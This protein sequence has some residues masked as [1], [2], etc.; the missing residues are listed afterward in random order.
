MT[1]FLKNTK[2]FLLSFGILTMAGGI[3][4]LIGSKVTVNKIEDERDN[5][6]S[7]YQTTEEFH[8]ARQ[9]RRLS[10]DN[11]FKMEALSENEYKEKL[12]YLDSDEFTYECLSKNKTEMAVKYKN[13][14][15]NLTTQIENKNQLTKASM[16]ITLAGGGIAAGGD[17]IKIDKYEYEEE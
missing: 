9:N 14:I 6:Y 16:L 12:K 3:G 1:G 13:N 17:Y 2:I 8:I 11:A 5:F 4:L 7:Q 15:D 10:Y